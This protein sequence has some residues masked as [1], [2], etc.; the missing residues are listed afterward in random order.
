MVKDEG[1]GCQVCALI[2]LCLLTAPAVLWCL[3]VNERLGEKCKERLWVMG[4]T[5]SSFSKDAPIMI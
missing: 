1:S 4:L 5:G 2:N 3:L